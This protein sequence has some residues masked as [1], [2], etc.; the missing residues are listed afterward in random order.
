MQC[1]DFDLLIHLLG[2]SRYKANCTFA[3]AHGGVA[4]MDVGEVRELGAASFAYMD[5]GEVRELGAASF[6]TPW[7]RQKIAPAFSAYSPSVDINDYSA[8]WRL[9][10]HHRKRTLRLV[11]LRIPG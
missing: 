8:S 10:L 2:E 5:V 1:N 7:N 6:A 4:Y 3:A 11:Q 9:A